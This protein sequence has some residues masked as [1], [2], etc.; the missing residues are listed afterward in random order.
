M[1]LKTHI[2]GTGFEGRTAVIRRHCK[3]HMDVT[4]QRERGNA[5]DKNAVAVYIDVPVLFGLLGST[6]QQI[7]YIKADK[8]AALAKHMDDGGAVSAYVDY[9]WPASDTYYNAKVR[10]GVCLEGC[11]L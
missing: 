2:A 1:K 3:T 5:H 11:T 7:G 6:P 9:C 8:N 4:L 10:L